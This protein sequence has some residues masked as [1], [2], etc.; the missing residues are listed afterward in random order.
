MIVKDLKHMAESVMLRAS[1]WYEGRIGFIR[2]PVSYRESYNQVTLNKFVD[3]QTSEF[4]RNKE[5][6]R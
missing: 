2:T 4:R 1:G 6:S 3:N 5:L